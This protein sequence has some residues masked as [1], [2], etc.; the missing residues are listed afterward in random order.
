MLPS[1]A[2]EALADV[3]AGT[4][5]IEPRSSGVV[6]VSGGADS[7]CAAAAL[8]EVLGP[9]SVS[10]IHLNYALR[11][12]ADEDER[13]ARAL[14]A[15]LRIDL[16]VERPELGEGNV[17]AL[18]RDARY[19]AA[20]RLCDRLGASWVA[21][22][23]T[24]TDIAETMLYRLAVSPG[25]RPL[26]GLAPRNGRVVRPLHSVSR[27]E[28]RA[29]AAG[30]GLPFH[31]DPTNATGAYARNRIRHEVLPV[32]TEI[33]AEVERNLAATHAELHE[34]AEVLSG[35]VDAALAEAGV[36]SERDRDR[37]RR[38][39]R[40]EH[41]SAPA[42]APRA[43]RAGGEAWRGGESLAGG[44]D[45]PPRGASRGRRRRARRRARGALRVGAGALRGH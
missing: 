22:G 3:V 12:D 24:R 20:A 30:A 11:L 35:V 5:L 29:I 44:D 13:A 38:A 23:H 18:A 25:T 16:H 27:E 45:R 39:A 28:T 9:E 15:Q 14:C 8:V 10:A 40:D 36:G 4:G 7:A 19:A 17:Q 32:L 6:L 42:G 43:R 31:D 1:P 2:I 21:T 26:L 33:G 41:R 37:R 34:E